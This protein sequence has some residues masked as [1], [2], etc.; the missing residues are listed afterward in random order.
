MRLI[1]LCNWIKLDK[2]EDRGKHFPYVAHQHNCNEDPFK[3]A[4]GYRSGVIGLEKLA[5]G[6]CFQD[7]SKVWV[8][9]V[10]IR[11]RDYTHFS[12]C[13]KAKLLDY[14]TVQFGGIKW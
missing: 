10:Q 13:D 8:T 3:L 12:F 11:P 1:L 7:H 6:I 4:P 2:Y 5:L 9:S 14:L